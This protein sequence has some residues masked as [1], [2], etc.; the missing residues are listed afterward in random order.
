MVANCTYFIDWR[1]DSSLQ[2]HHLQELVER[3]KFKN[4][5]YY[6]HLSEGLLCI[7]P[8]IVFI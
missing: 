4:D 6:I 2:Y 5:T 7:V 1:S 8:I 3:I